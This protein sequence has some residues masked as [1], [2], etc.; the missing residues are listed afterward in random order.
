[1]KKQVIVMSRHQ[2]ESAIWEHGPIISIAG[3]NDVQA[4]LEG[5]DWHAKLRVFF[6]DITTETNGSLL[7]GEQDAQLIKGY[8]GAYC[9]ADMI[10]VHC[11]A[12]V[13]RSVAVG[14][15]IAE[16]QDR[17]LVLCA[18]AGT[19]GYNVHVYNMLNHDGRMASLE[20]AFK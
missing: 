1:M 10:Y 19:S 17:V 11:A 2:A 18:A 5:N 8:V 15:W 20:E 9:D 4:D 13:S 6:D 12:G 7:F 16:T 3:S 14:M